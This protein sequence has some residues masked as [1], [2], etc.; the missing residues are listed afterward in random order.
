M[1]VPFAVTICVQE[2]FGNVFSTRAARD[3]STPM[4]TPIAIEMAKNMSTEAM[5][6]SRA[7]RTLEHTPPFTQKPP[8]QTGKQNH[9]TMKLQRMSSSLPKSWKLQKPKRQDTTELVHQKANVVTLTLSTHPTTPPEAV[10][11][12]AQPQHPLGTR[13]GALAGTP[14][15]VPPLASPALYCGK[16]GSANERVARDISKQ[17][18][19]GGEVAVRTRLRQLES[20]LEQ[21]H[22]LQHVRKRILQTESK[23]YVAD[24]EFLEELAFPQR[25]LPRVEAPS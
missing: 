16:T 13:W 12:A 10:L 21:T 2:K 9:P 11:A 14:A 18:R 17:K 24:T 3:T 7:V 20:C 6:K 25:T 23:Q 15:L 19:R 4:V 5:L 1:V 8:N 22:T